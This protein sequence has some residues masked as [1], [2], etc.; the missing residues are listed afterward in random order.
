M[1]TM[2]YELELCFFFELLLIHLTICSFGM[3]N[4]YSFLKPCLQSHK[5]YSKSVFIL[6]SNPLVIS[7]VSCENM[8]IFLIQEQ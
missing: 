4:I 6:N 1:H 3:S 8:E 5:S 7:E 2:D